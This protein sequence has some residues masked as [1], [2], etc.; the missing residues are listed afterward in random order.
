M[1]GTRHGRG[2]RV[3]SEDGILP[4]INVVFLLLVFFMLAGQFV[5]QGPFP[6]EP[7]QSV[8][9]TEAGERE[10]E[11]LIG[12]DG[13]VAVGDTVVTLAD[14]PAELDRLMPADRSSTVWVKADANASAGGLLD[15][16][17]AARAAGVQEVRLLTILAT[18]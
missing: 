4:L 3:D 11:I 13:R 1:R 9:E 10:V 12:R 15:V 8:S 18:P 17:D 7:T 5:T 14:L 16:I 6:L 2:L